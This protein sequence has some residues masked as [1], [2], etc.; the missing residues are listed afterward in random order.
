L[1]NAGTGLA[2]LC[3]DDEQV[4]LTSLTD[5]IRGHFGKRFSYET[6]LDGEEALEV[7]DELTAEGVKTLVIVSDWLMPGMK[8]DELLIEIHKRFPKTVKVMLTGQAD[9]VAVERARRE[10]ALYGYLQKPWSR[11][12]LLGLIERGLTERGGSS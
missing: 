7:L 11:E 8:G 1:T 5:Q 12:E 10:A 3:V 9:S 2:V 4:I 6:A